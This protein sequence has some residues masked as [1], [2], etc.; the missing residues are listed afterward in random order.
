MRV[1]DTPDE[2]PL[3]ALGVSIFRGIESP[4]LSV[5]CDRLLTRRFENPR[6]TR[7]NIS[8]STEYPFCIIKQFSRDSY[9]PITQDTYSSNHMYIPAIF[10]YLEEILAKKNF[11][12]TKIYIGNFF[13]PE[14]R[15]FTDLSN[16]LKI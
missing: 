4:A 7:T 6:Y 8:D 11:C 2:I 9:I 16:L 1:P 10:T 3:F 5:T 13:I 14:I 12:C 15:Y